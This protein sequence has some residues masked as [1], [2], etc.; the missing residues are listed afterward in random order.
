MKMSGTQLL[1][2]ADDLPS[3]PK[4]KKFWGTMKNPR[5][6]TMAENLATGGESMG[7]M[8]ADGL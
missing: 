7:N 1:Q 6:R 3:P 2:T 8:L 5:E 4:M